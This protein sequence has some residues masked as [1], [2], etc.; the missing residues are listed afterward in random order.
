MPSTAALQTSQ[1]VQ[2]S[3][4]AAGCAPT[5]NLCPGGGALCVQHL[6]VTHS[7]VVLRR[8]QR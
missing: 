2:G 6:Q 3:H 5:P 4:N 8:K 1:E 7:F